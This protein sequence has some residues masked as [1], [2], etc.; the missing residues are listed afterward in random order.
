MGLLLVVVL[1]GAAL[2]P[3]CSSGS[4]C[5]VGSERCSCTS[6]GAC[7]PGLTCA[8]SLC[9]R[10]TGT[11]GAA[12]MTGS[13]G[14][15]GQGTDAATDGRGDAAG[16]FLAQCVPGLMVLVGDLEGQSVDL[17]TGQHP[18]FQQETLPYTAD[19]SSTQTGDVQL[20]LAFTSSIGADQKAAVTGT[21]VL[22][23]GAPHATEQLCVGSGSLWYEDTDAGD[24]FVL[25][26]T[27]EML[28]AG[29]TC[30]GTSLG[31]RIDGCS[32]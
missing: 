24:R 12:G 9:V 17:Q 15:T 14:A 7:D 26:F 4:S 25:R 1:S 28:S 3:A 32:N 6:G 21:L 31:G 19:F 27:L 13:A 11:G 8:S 23:A 16:G 20:H 29:P 2:I 18:T 5:A 10:L 22:P 30:P